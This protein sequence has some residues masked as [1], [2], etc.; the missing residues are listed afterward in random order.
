[1]RTNIVRANELVEEIL[2]TLSADELAEI[3]YTIEVLKKKYLED[4]WPEGGFPIDCQNRGLDIGH[5]NARQRLYLVQ[6]KYKVVNVWDSRM[7]DQT[8]TLHLY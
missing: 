7:G 2:E 4:S 8:I 5:L 1:M 6:L 3:K